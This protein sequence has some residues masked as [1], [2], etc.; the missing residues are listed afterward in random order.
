MNI[1]QASWED[2]RTIALLN[3]HV[4]QIH[5]DIRPDLYKQAELSDELIAVYED[6]LTD[7]KGV[8]YLAEDDGVAVGY[9]YVMIRKRPESLF[10]QI[11]HSILVDQMS[12]N[13]DYYGTGVADMLMQCVTDLAQE[14]GI[15]RVTLDVLD[16]NIR[17]R[18][19]YEKQGF[20]TFKH[21][22]EMMLE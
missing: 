11:R 2:A 18:K 12:V 15:K 14:N 5:A 22:M 17:A 6:W 9:I 10:T 7:D 1:R 16:W 3:Q 4:Q 20:T 21:S 8:L 13:P 19:F